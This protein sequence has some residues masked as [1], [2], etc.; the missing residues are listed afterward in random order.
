MGSGGDQAGHF[1]HARS[2]TPARALDRGCF[3]TG[4]AGAVGAGKDLSGG[5]CTAAVGDAD[6]SRIFRRARHGGDGQ[7]G[8]WQCT[9]VVVH[10]GG[11][12]CGMKNQ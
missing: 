12:K 10:S 7:F 5:R 4:G 6:T 2:R 8:T 9:V 3:S 1:Q 11:G